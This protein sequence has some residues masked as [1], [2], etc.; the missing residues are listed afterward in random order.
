MHMKMVKRNKLI[1]VIY[2]LF[3]IFVIKTKAASGRKHASLSD[4]LDDLDLRSDNR[5]RPGYGEGAL[6]IHAF[7]HI[8]NIIS[9]NEIDS[10]ITVSLLLKQIWID[11]RL[12]YPDRNISEILIDNSNFM[13][14]LWTPDTFI[15]N[16]VRTHCWDDRSL[17]HQIIRLT[18]DVGHK[19]D[20]IVY[21]WRNGS[22]SVDYSSSLKSLV[23]KSYSLVSAETHSQ[24]SFI[25]T[26]GSYS[27]LTLRLQF[28][29]LWLRS[30]ITFF[31]PSTSLTICSLLGLWIIREKYAVAG[32][33][34]NFSIAG[35][36]IFMGILAYSQMPLV[37]VLTPVDVHLGIC[38]STIF[39]SVTFHALVLCLRIISHQKGRYIG[40]SVT[41]RKVFHSSSSSSSQ[42]LQSQVGPKGHYKTNAD[43]V[44]DDVDTED[45]EREYSDDA[46]APSYYV[47]AQEHDG[48]QTLRG[49]NECDSS[50]ETHQE[51]TKRSSITKTKRFLTLLLRVSLAGSKWTVLLSFVIAESYF[52]YVYVLS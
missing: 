39:S 26:G 20:E 34:L 5:V 25:S 35:F 36:V 50:E 3:V 7:A 30:F 37:A 4:I 8:R 9:M 44:V 12:A 49:I 21:L 42:K 40:R 24:Q 19:T 2:F 33:V 23:G 11:P 48:K 18:P 38:L 14:R 29:K 1:S 13:S 51:D 43:G 28:A 15:V 10:T 46:E 32:I 41:S 27:K 31:L 16:E 47:T 17:A 52:W 6:E 45:G 22:K